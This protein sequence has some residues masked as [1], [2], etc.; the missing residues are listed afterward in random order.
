MRLGDTSV[1]SNTSSA[2]TVTIPAKA[3]TLTATYKD[4]TNI[5]TNSLTATDYRMV[6]LHSHHNRTRFS[7]AAT[8]AAIHTFTF[9]CCAY[10][11]PC[12]AYTAL[13]FY[14]LDRAIQGTCS[15]FHTCRWLYEFSMFFSFGKNSMWADL[16]T[17]PAVDAPVR[18]ILER[19]LKIR[20][21]HSDHLHE[22]DYPQ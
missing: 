7:S 12:T 8:F 18:M 11:C 2:N 14:C 10:H 4:G 1:A 6:S 21:K 3:S 17:A 13:H 15:T 5:K 20:I 22:L 16:R 9:E 19:I